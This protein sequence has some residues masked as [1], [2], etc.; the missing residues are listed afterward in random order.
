MARN[1]GYR[2]HRISRSRDDWFLVAI[3]HSAA[4]KDV[5]RLLLPVV[6]SVPLI[7][8]YHHDLNINQIL[9][10]C[11]R[12]NAPLWGPKRC[13][14][15][16]THPYPQD[17]HR[18]CF[19]ACRDAPWRCLETYFKNISPRTTF[20]YSAASICPRSL[21]SAAQSFASNPRLAPLPLPVSLVFGLP[22]AIFPLIP[23]NSTSWHASF[24]YSAF[25]VLEC[26][27]WW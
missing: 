5:K 8:H 11:L 21:S 24:P 13:S 2:H 15:S 16:G 27:G 22:R 7:D 17:R 20:L 4:S 12:S 3:F 26:H 1:I 6:K 10:H 23:A 18:A 25:S 19:S 14:P 9:Y